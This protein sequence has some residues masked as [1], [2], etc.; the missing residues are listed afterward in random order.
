[1]WADILGLT[2]PSVGLVLRTRQVELLA[3]RGR[4][5]ITSARVPIEG[6]EPR[7]CTDA[8]R[9]ALA[10]GGVSTRTLAVSIP[11]QNVL[12][13][14]FT[15]PTIPKPEWEAAIQFEARKYIPF[16]LEEL[17]WDYRVMPVPAAK[18]LEVIF[19]AIQRDI[20]LRFQDILRAAEV[21]PTLIEPT[22][23]SLA[24]LVG[25]PHGKP[26][27]EFACVVDV[28]GEAAHLAIVKH[29]T[30]YLTREINLSAAPAAPPMGIPG[31]EPTGVAEAQTVDFDAQAPRR[32]LTELNVSMDFFVREYPSTAITRVVLFGEEQLMDAWCRSLAGQLRSPVEL[33]RPLLDQRLSGSL[34][35]P[36]ASAVGLAQAGSPARGGSIDL[37][38][39]SSPKA[40][41]PSRLPV[42]MPTAATVTELISSLKEGRAIVLSGVLALAILL[43]AWVA[44]ASQVA[45]VQRRLDQLR[46]SRPD[47]GWGLTGRDESELRPLQ[48]NAT[49]QLAL[50]KH[51]IEERLSVAEVLDALARSLPD[52]VWLT[53]IT[54]DGAFDAAGKNPAR[55]LISGASFLGEAGQE[56]SAI[57]QFEEQV[58]H[59]PKLLKGFSSAQLDQISAQTQP[60]NQATY[61]TFQLNCQPSR[62]L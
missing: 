38:R 19:A 59:H 13:R 44:G 7:H 6:D 49:A 29:G 47:V 11:T 9:R 56:L 15:I 25:A 30:P 4:Q 2:Q 23:V 39:R 41:T 12:F 45:V 16:K 60:T 18:R 26:S 51:L 36:F 57:Q 28:E 46:Q 61:R 10:T 8:V 5:V 32:L 37:L 17:V 3:L 43:S 31:A 42:A 52:G 21:Q 22:S 53:K 54:Y 50:L 1:M 27:H 14:F 55:L 33:G 35:L 58:K 24:R 34:P 40:P 20:F 48:E 62:R